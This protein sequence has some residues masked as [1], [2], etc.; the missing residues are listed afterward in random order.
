M[1]HDF[2]VDAYKNVVKADKW[3]ARQVE[4]LK[5]VQADGIR[6]KLVV[7]VQRVDYMSHFEPG[8]GAQMELKQVGKNI[9]KFFKNLNRK[10]KLILID[11][12]H[13][14]LIKEKY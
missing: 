13:N 6:Q 4:M 9:I 14:F 1:D 7:Q 3:V 12:I 11:Q 5:R 2:L 10:L 8:N